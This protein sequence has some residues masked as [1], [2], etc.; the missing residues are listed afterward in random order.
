MNLFNKAYSGART[1]DPYE[2]YEP[3]NTELQAIG[4]WNKPEELNNVDSEQADKSPDYDP[5]NEDWKQER[6]VSEAADQDDATE[7]TADKEE[8]RSRSRR[9]RKRRR[10]SSTPSRNR[11][12]TRRSSRPR[13]RRRRS[14]SSR[15][16]SAPRRRK[17]KAPA[18]VEP[19][20]C[21]DA[22][23]LPVES[24]PSSVYPEDDDSLREEMQVV[25]NMPK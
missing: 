2:L 12:R 3:G 8:T 9:K 15:S 24:S 4:P 7:T 21:D 13:R 25:F 6:S 19:E 16:L 23:V 1:E 5:H 11:R 22:E 17:S 20:E 18:I 14:T 10:R